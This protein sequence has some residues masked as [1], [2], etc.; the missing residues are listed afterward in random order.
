MA[1][2]LMSI[3]ATGL[4]SPFKRS[5]LWKEA[6]ACMTDILCVQETHFKQASPIRLQ[7]R[8]FPHIYFANAD[9]KR[10]GVLIALRDSLA[11]QLVHSYADPDERFI[12]LVCDINNIRCTLVNVYTPNTRPVDSWQDE[13]QQQGPKL[14][15]LF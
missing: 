12:I 3:N 8:N 11:F 14:K 7:H 6:N 1:V 10:A 4:N 15:F 2:N 5:V 9:T 13:L